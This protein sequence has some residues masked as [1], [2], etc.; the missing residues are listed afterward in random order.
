MWMGYLLGLI[1]LAQNSPPQPGAAP[2]LYIECRLVSFP[3]A[4]VDLVP[5]YFNNLIQQSEDKEAATI[6]LTLTDQL[7]ATGELKVTLSFVSKTTPLI[8]IGPFEMSPTLEANQPAHLAQQWL[9]AWID[10]GVLTHFPPEDRAQTGASGVATQSHDMDLGVGAAVQSRKFENSPFY[11]NISLSGQSFSAGKPATATTVN[12]RSSSLNANGRVLLNYSTPRIRAIGDV[13]S[14]YAESSYPG[15]AGAQVEASNFTKG[16]SIMTIY[17][18]AKRW[19]VAVIRTSDSNPGSNIQRDQYQSGGVEWTLVPFRVKETRE[20]A[21]RTT[22][23]QN[24]KALLAPNDRG[25]TEERLA[26]AFAALRFFW[27]FDE[28]RAVVNARASAFTVLSLKGYESYSASLDLGY[29]I[30]RPIR[31]SVGLTY[32]YLKRSLTYPAAP[33]FSNP[34]QTTFLG[35]QP[36][37]SLRFSFG[38]TATL[39]NRRRQN[40]DR[41]WQ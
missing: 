36:G 7:L 10:Q 15:A 6:A 22:V 9:F 4:C 41:R 35:G 1:A 8:S 21:I 11:L 5:L 24:N 3:T 14:G 20:L 28:G 38:M 31:V 40:E 19:S 29:Q 39:G 33:D 34:Y 13:H 2:T 27:M 30:L 25:N 26:Y 16:F 18:V 12:T 17:S 37:R 32:G 23:G